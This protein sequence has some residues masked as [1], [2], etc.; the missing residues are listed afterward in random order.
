MKKIHI[1]ILALTLRAFTASALLLGIFHDYDSVESQSPEIFVASCTTDP[2]TLFKPGTQ[3]DNV[4]TYAIEILTPIKGTNQPGDAILNSLHWL[5]VGDT[6]LIFG[7]FRDGAYQA[8]EDYRVVP[9]GRA[10]FSVGEITNSIAG[11]S[12]DEQLQI[13][14]KRALDNVNRQMK[15]EQEEKQRF[16]DSIRK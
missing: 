10:I 2:P 5:N 1:L 7:N 6:Y 9:L 14:F 8:F 3:T 12:E 15:Q 11:K 16:E 13:L 4:N